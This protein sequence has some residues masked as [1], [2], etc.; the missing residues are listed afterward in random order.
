MIQRILYKQNKH[1]QIFHSDLETKFLHLSG[2]YGSGK[3]F[4]LIQKTFQLSRLNRNLNGGLVCPSFADFKRDVM[5]LI[6]EVC[7]QNRIKYKYHKTEHWYRFPWSSGRVFVATAEK[8]LKGPNWAFAAINELTLLPFDRYREVISRVRL[9]KASHPQIASC[10]TP[11]GLL[12]GYYKFFIEEPNKRSKVIYGSTD[13]NLINLNEDYLQ[14]L[15]SAYD[16]VA[17]QAYR[18][19]A[20]LNIQ[21]NRF[22]YSFADEKN[23]CQSTE[24]SDEPVLISMDFNV[25]PMVATI[26]QWQQG[27]TLDA[28]DG[29]VLPQNA[30]TK[31]MCVA[32]MQRG[33][34]PDRVT[35]FPDPAGNARSTKGQPDLV[36]LRNAGYDNIKVRSVAPPFR[37]RQLN[38]NNLLEKGTIRVN[39]KLAPFMYRDFLLCTQD[40]VTLEKEKSSPELTHASD[41]AD[42]MLDLLFEFSGRKPQSYQTKIR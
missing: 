9:K 18:H 16:S 2:G 30:D 35:I 39:K 23:L 3:T 1:Q 8:P 41:G 34:T 10:G 15:E 12:S 13:D 21:G 25:D 19:G 29:I 38:V 26:W 32:M 11:E 37:K 20:F 22:Y 27:G 17:L 14:D 5:V 40:I 6:E 28:V 42:Y 7:D 31:K 4:G 36:I 24:N 33:Y